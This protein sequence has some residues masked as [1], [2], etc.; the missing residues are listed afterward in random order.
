M[1]VKHLI[2]ELQKL[3]P[4]SVLLFSCDIDNFMSS[5]GCAFDADYSLQ[6][7]TN[8]EFKTEVDE[9]EFDSDHE[10]EF[11]EELIEG[12]NTVTT[13]IVVFRVS[14]DANWDQ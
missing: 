1:I 7:F 3:N 6:S 11:K 13:G 8:E 14:G 9:M 5:S 10:D 2:E 12:I 4:E